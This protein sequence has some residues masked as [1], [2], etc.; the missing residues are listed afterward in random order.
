MRAGGKT[1]EAENG[2][3]AVDYLRT[4]AHTVDGVLMDVQMPVL[5]GLAATRLI[6]DELQLHELPV[7]AITAGVSQDDRQKALDAGVN[8]FITKPIDMVQ[9]LQE[10]EQQLLNLQL[11][12][13]TPRQALDLLY[14]LKQQIK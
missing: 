3:V 12:D 14:V 7:I 5:D 2:K 6:R 4:Q 10:I 1:V 9:A 13:L 8:A 11:D